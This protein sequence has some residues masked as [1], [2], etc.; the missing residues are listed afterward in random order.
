[1]AS[2]G[3]LPGKSGQYV[4]YSTPGANGLLAGVEL[5]GQIDWAPGTQQSS[6]KEHSLKETGAVSMGQ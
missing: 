1:M 5:T 2:G 6:A 4:Q 3:N